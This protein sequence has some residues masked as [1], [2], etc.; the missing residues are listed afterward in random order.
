MLHIVPHPTRSVSSKFHID[1]ITFTS[2]AHLPPKSLYHHEGY[3][4]L[5][6]VVLVLV[7]AGFVIVVGLLALGLTVLDAAA[8]T[9]QVSKLI[10]GVEAV[11]ER[12]AG[13]AVSVP[14]R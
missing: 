2:T 1:Q 11:H 14:V 13:A 3:F 5:L 6:A 8:A 9:L 10:H 4:G 12:S 7:A